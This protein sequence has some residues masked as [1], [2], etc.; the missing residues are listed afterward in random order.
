M[1]VNS[2]RGHHSSGLVRMIA[3]AL[4]VGLSLSCTGHAV[5][6]P[7]AQDQ[8]PHRVLK[9][10]GVI[11]AIEEPVPGYTAYGSDGG[12]V[13]LPSGALQLGRSGPEDSGYEDYQ[14]A[15]FGLLVHRAR[16]ASLKIVSAPADAFLDYH[17][18]ERG[19]WSAGAL[20][21]GPCDTHGPLCEPDSAGNTP[22]W[23]CG[24]DRG[25]WLVWAG[26][27]WVNEPGCVEVLVSSEDEE[28]RV[29]LAVGASCD[30]EA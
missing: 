24:A 22:G 26:G 9:C 20:T 21:V 23:P 11:D 10:L 12:F 5:D 6:P 7:E 19:V 1:R 8:A 30:G 27:I 29:Q 18:D 3:V 17:R 4:M 16:Q 15:K 28:I 2:P 13:A 25:E 14:F